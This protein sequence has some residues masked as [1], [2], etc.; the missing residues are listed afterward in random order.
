MI[1]FG[2]VLLTFPFV[3]SPQLIIRDLGFIA[4]CLQL[5]TVFPFAVSQGGVESR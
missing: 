2:I 4:T 5:L 3:L 1:G